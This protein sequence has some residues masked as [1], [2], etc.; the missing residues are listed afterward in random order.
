MFSCPTN[1]RNPREEDRQ[2]T[3]KGRDETNRTGMDVNKYFTT[4]FVYYW[5]FVVNGLKQCK[6]IHGKVELLYHNNL[7]I[8]GKEWYDFWMINFEDLYPACIHGFF[9]MR[10]RGVSTKTLAEDEG[11]QWKKLMMQHIYSSS[12]IKGGN[13]L[14]W[15]AEEFG[16][17]SII[18]S[19]WNQQLDH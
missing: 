4:R 16:K 15:F 5:G 9:Q 13:G 10:S 7:H 19:M 14:Q 8:D 12:C 6:I 18:V 11:K 17:G 3:I 2:T 1:P